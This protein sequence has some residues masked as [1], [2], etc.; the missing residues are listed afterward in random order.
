M[1]LT[2]LRKKEFTSFD[3]AIAVHELKETIADARVN[4]IYQLNEKTII[5]K[6]HKTD[7]PPLRLVMEAGVR[8]HLTAYALKPPKV[9]PAFCMALRKYLRGAWVDNVEQY[10]F[11]RVVTVQFRT[12][13]GVL[14]LILELFG[15]GNIILTGEKGEILQ[16]LFFKRMRDRNIVRNEVYQFPPSSGKNPF[17]LTKDELKEAVNT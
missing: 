10:E 14:R 17:N 9:P 16:A 11:E 12:K 15:E 4:N 8:L 6:L 13:I 5:L 2:P 3:V 7:K 1:V